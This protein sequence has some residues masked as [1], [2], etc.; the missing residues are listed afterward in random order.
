[1]P[2]FTRETSDGTV[3]IAY[4]DTGGDGFPI[5]M[6]AAGALRSSAKYWD[7]APWNPAREQGPEYRFIVMDQRNAGRSS[8]PITADHGWATYTQDQLAL[9]DHVGAE[10][11]GVMGMCIGGPF[12]MGLIEAASERVAC[13]VVFQP[14]GVDDNRELFHEMQA[15]WATE[16]PPEAGNVSEDTLAALR[17]NLWDDESKFMFNVDEA[18]VSSVDTPLLVLMG[19]DPAHPPAISRQVVELAHNAELIEEWKTEPGRS[20]AMARTAEFLAQH[21]GN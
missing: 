20:A 15:G 21:T 13:G 5:L 1:M 16:L 2:T 8:A 18:F 14:I 17:R 4:D 11:F 9:M 12:I 10:R 3:N 6:I 7:E 19:N